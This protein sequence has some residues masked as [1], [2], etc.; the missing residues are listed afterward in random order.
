MSAANEWKFFNKRREILYG[1]HVMFCWFINEI[2]HQWNNKPFH[3]VDFLRDYSRK[4]AIY[5]VIIVIVIR[6]SL[7]KVSC[8]RVNDHLPFHWRL[9][10]KNIWNNQRLE[11]CVRCAL[12]LCN[13]DLRGFWLTTYNRQGHNRVHLKFTTK[14]LEKTVNSSCLA[15]DRYQH[16]IEA[17]SVSQTKMVSDQSLKWPSI[18]D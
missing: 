2:K 4:G 14:Q 16:E 13:R 10:K 9:N 11:K 7:V 5:H 8:F 3:L 12:L 17:T 1:V 18:C 15:P 6:L